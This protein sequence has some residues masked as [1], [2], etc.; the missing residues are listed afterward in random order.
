MKA[1]QIQDSDNPAFVIALDWKDAIE[2]WRR[3]LISEYGDCEPHD[4]EG[5]ANADPDRGVACLCDDDELILELGKDP[6]KADL[7]TRLA[8]ALNDYRVWKSS[9]KTHM[10][11]IERMSNY[12][13][14]IAELAG[15]PISTP[16][17]D[18]LSELREHI[19]IRLRMAD[20]FERLRTGSPSGAVVS[21]S[22]LDAANQQ[23]AWLCEAAVGREG[24]T[25][26]EAMVAVRRMRKDG[27]ATIPRQEIDDEKPRGDGSEA[28][29]N[30][31]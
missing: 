30:P 5:L 17:E 28:E 29:G 13:Y 14:R 24:A 8:R 10:A 7:E 20:A 31:A 19:R 2:A 26:Q 25:L 15:T 23:I 4:I 6:D 21:Q 27:T 9:A 22:A 11:T 3:H 16:S 18:N 12:I 1:F